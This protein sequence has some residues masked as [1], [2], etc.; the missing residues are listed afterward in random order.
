MADFFNTQEDCLVGVGDV[1]R[2]EARRGCSSV[3]N[4]DKP[5]HKASGSRRD[6]ISVFD[7][8][9]VTQIRIQFKCLEHSYCKIRIHNSLYIYIYIYT[10]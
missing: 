9:F 1:R 3:G 6:S 4:E 7:C 10:Q 8:M 5:R 2:G